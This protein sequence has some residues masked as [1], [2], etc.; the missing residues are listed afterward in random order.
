MLVLVPVPVLARAAA[1]VSTSLLESVSVPVRSQCV[2]F[3]F[4]ICDT[5]TVPRSI[6]WQ[7]YPH[8]LFQ[9]HED[10]SRFSVSSGIFSPTV[11]LGFLRRRVKSSCTYSRQL[12]TKQNKITEVILESPWQSNTIHRSSS[13]YLSADERLNERTFLFVNLLYNVSRKEQ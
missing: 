13:L 6:H 11:I 4:I 12:K 3:S 8:C 10:T 9:W 7:C 5:I 1:P 2:E